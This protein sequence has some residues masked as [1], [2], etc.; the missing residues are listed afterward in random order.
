MTTRSKAEIYIFSSILEE[1]NNCCGGCASPLDL[2]RDHV[3]P[4]NAG[5]SD[6]AENLQVLCHHCNNKK[7]GLVGVARFSPR[8][9]EFN[10]HAILENRAIFNQLIEEHR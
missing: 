10:I 7:N 1:Y 3:H 6:D 8:T 4:R 9:P 2:E 5:G